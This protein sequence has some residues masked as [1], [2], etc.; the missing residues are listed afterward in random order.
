M[1]NQAVRVPLLILDLLLIVVFTS[2]CNFSTPAPSPT[3]P[4]EKDVPVE[5][6]PLIS[7]VNPDTDEIVPASYQSILPPSDLPEVAFD[8]ELFYAERW[9]RVHQTV[10]IK[11]LSPDAWEEVVFNVPI[12]YTPGSFMLDTVT[13]VL[14]DMTQEGT[15]P[16]FG[17]ETILRVPL[18]SPVQTGGSVHIEMGYRVIFPAVASTDWP[19]IGTTGWTENLIQAG[20]WYPS[21]VPYIEGEGWHTWRYHPVGDPTFYPLTNVSLKITTDQDVTVA[22]G[23]LL[24]QK[25]GVWQFRVD[26]ARGIAFIASPHYQLTERKFG[27]I[28]L[29]SYYFP[30]HA[31]AGK[32]ALD[33]AENAI[34]LFSEIYGPYPYQSLTIAENGFFGGMEYSEMISITDYCYRTY[35]GEPN[36]VLN[37]LVAHETAHQWWY[38]AVANDQANEPWLDESLAFYSELLYFEHYYPEYTQWWWE[39]RVD[40]YNPYGPV[41]ATIYSYE[42]SD[43]FIP[44]MYGQA[45]RFIR[46]LRKLM[47]DDDFFAFLQD[48]QATYRWSS[49]TAQDFFDTVRRHHDGDLTPLLKAYFAKSD[50]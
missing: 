39:K 43:Y 35:R 29:S 9:M 31:E 1:S 28:L 46:E 16:L 19:P 18:P 11:N 15:P 34:K 20:E 47:G 6:A 25:D 13:V 24:E 42:R 22:S 41:D 38:G 4:V 26:A 33:V 17:Q 32:V 3:Q 49:V 14:G 44:S 27:D 2:G 30:E 37:A 21:L 23:G 50:W 36:S 40:I 48:Y 7:T 10:D 12:N 45:A 5:S 8:V